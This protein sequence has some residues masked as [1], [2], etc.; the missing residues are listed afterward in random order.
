MSG[1]PSGMIGERVRAWR[2]HRRLGVDELAARSG[3]PQRFLAQAERGEQRF[4]RWWQVAQVADVLEV[5]ACELAGQPYLPADPGDSRVGAAVVRIRRVLLEA[6]SSELGQVPRRRGELG[7]RVAEATRLR[8]YGADEELARRLPDLLADLI[9]A[10]REESAAGPWQLLVEACDSTAVLLTRLGVVDLAWTCVERMADA[11]RRAGEAA[12]GLVEL[13]RADVLLAIGA[14]ARAVEICRR[15]VA[16][17]DASRD[18]GVMRLC[19]MLL[20]T[21]SLAAAALNRPEAAFGFLRDAEA[22]ADRVSGDNADGWGLAF[23]P[24]TL[25]V[26]RL[27]V[28]VELGHGADAVESARS[29]DP[30]RLVPGEQVAAYYTGL[31]RAYALV[32]RYDDAL[33]ALLRAEDAAAFR[34]R[35]DPLVR[36]LVADMMGHARR[37]AGGRELRGIARRL[38][39]G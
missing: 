17:Q 29:T 28:L 10:A 15:A 26:W 9:V 32:D 3:L 12:A 2:R 25:G 37:E 24:E 27:G 7:E 35:I 36:E 16:G 6:G 39:L 14:R 18:R 8:L 4:E 38:G 20:A 5:P 13:R 23:G 22:V 30:G 1:E 21:A 11:A 34:I 19:G 31:A 33:R